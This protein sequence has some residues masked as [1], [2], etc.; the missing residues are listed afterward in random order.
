[1]HLLVYKVIRRGWIFSVNKTALPLSAC[2]LESLP[3]LSHVF[4]CNFLPFGKCPAH[5]G[6]YQEQEQPSYL[7]ATASSRH[8]GKTVYFVL[9][10]GTSG[11]G[12]KEGLFISSAPRSHR[13]FLQFTL[14]LYHVMSTKCSTAHQLCTSS[15]RIKQGIIW[16]CAILLQGWKNL[17]YSPLVEWPRKEKANKT[18]AWR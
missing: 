1:M 10:L 12:G 7:S 9:T 2:C 16:L 11:T 13:E 18:I 17:G 3:S 4:S 8:F 15:S 6:H 5:F 14:L